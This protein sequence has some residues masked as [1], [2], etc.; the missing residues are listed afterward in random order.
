MS[1][2]TQADRFQQKGLRGSADL[3]LE[4][5]G[6]LASNVGGLMGGVGPIS[7]GVSSIAEAAL[8]QPMGSLGAL[9][10]FTGFRQPPPA[11]R[12]LYGNL[13]DYQKG[14]KA[15]QSH[16]GGIGSGTGASGGGQG[17]RAGF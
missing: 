5:M 12:R 14:L 2:T 17:E 7:T 4:N 15:S 13:I 1:G 9:Q 8:G 3:S 16:S 6:K 10:N 11:K